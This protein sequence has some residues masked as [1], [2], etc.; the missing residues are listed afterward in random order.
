MYHFFSA[1]GDALMPLPG[2]GACSG[3]LPL[4][5]GL[6]SS[7]L[8]I[9]QLR[10]VR[11]D[12]VEEAEDDRRDDRH[13]DHHERRRSDF[14]RGWPRDLLELGSHLVREVVELVVAIECDARDA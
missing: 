11:P 5:E 13:D 1:F 8:S 9:D 2:A 3:G 4:S 10:E 12:E 14:L 6:P 7:T